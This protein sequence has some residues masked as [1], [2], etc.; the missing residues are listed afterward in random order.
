MFFVFKDNP[1]GVLGHRGEITQ[2]LEGDYSISE[3]VD[4]HVSHIKNNTPQTMRHEAAHII[5]ALAIA[6][7]CGHLDE[8]PYQNNWF[9][10][11]Y[12][13]AIE[14]ELLRIEFNKTPFVFEEFR[15]RVRENAFFGRRTLSTTFSTEA[16]RYFAEEEAHHLGSINDD[17]IKGVW[18][19]TKPALDFIQQETLKRVELGR[20]K[21]FEDICCEVGVRDLYKSIFGYDYMPR[22]QTQPFASYD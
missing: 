13:I 5:L 17:Q 7:S 16:D 18:A 1:C 15:D 20:P 21:Y 22:A 3:G 10:E 14:A 12:V 19:L 9:S 11:S 8:R 6:N 2:M 4:L